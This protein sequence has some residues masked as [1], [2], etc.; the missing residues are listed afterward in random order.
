[1]AYAKVVWND[2]AVYE[3]VQAAPRAAHLRASLAAGAAAAAAIQSSG[4]GRLGNDVRIPKPIGPTIS[5]IGSSLVYAR[6][7][8]DGGTIL[9]NG[10][11]MTI[12]SSLRW[13]SGARDTT[14]RGIGGQFQNREVVA[15]AWKVTI[16]AKHYLDVAGPTYVSVFME[17]V[18][19]MIPG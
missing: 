11:P 19:S 18:A 3:I 5:A 15:F 6:I 10:K 8:N 16:P 9:A 1:M 14:G 17:T 13:P 7:Q 2:G 12:H 4:S